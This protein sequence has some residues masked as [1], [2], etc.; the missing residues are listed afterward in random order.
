MTEKKNGLTMS[1]IIEA[2][3]ANYSEGI[4][5]IAQLKKMTRSNGD[6]FTYISRQA[7]RYNIVNQLTWDNTPVQNDGVVQFAPL[8]KIDEY[9]EIDLFGY[10]KTTSKDK[11][12]G[13]AKGETRSRSAAVRLSNAISLEPYNSELDFLTNMGLSKRPNG[14]E[15]AIAQSEIHLSLYTY[16][17]T[18][19]LDRI[20]IDENDKINIQPAQKAE[21]LCAL[22]DV[23][24]FLW[25]DIKG[26]REN[27]NPVFAVGGL[28]NR[29]NPYFESRL[30]LDHGKLNIDLIK[31]IINSCDDTKENTVVGA[32]HG[33]FA[34][35]SEI[36]ELK[37]VSVSDMFNKVKADIIK[38]YA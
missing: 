6:V 23:I 36:N 17:I 34:N 11:E 20:G 31:D 12:K 19:D 21:R 24:Q 15:N 10:F 33:V 38:Y 37:P 26:R 30:E 1:F 8:A 9:P 7:L 13:K 18:V 27:L 28:Y 22:L 4:A 29:R 14:G 3:S 2:S 25:R 16:T 5:N 32:L 35:A